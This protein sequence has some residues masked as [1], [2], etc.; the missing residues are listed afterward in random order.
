MILPS[1][2]GAACSSLLHPCCLQVCRPLD[3]VST[4]QV[5]PVFWRLE[6]Y[7]I[8]NMGKRELYRPSDPRAP[9]WLK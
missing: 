2:T 9:I 3:R 8:S 1:H 5:Q 4:T 7:G 6:A